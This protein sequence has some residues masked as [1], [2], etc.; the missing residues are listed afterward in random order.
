MV[1]INLSSNDLILGVRG[2]DHPLPV[3]RKHGVPVAL[4]TDDEGV[5]RSHLTEE[6]LRAALTY[7]LSY[8][9]LKEMARNSLEYS[10][11]PGASY[12]RDGAYRLPVAAC[13]AGRQSEACR[14]ILEA[15]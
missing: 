1:E 11:L 2:K 4:S 14:E 5:S 8:A 10:F 9:D 15:Q 12:W 13:S 7:D 6:Y 3:Y